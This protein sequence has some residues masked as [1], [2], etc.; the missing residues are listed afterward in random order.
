MDDGGRRWRKRTT[1]RNGPK[2][3]YEILSLDIL[4]GKVAQV[5]SEISKI[6]VVKAK[7]YNHLSIQV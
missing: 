7:L 6:I 1:R 5:V 2:Y 3:Q 4:K